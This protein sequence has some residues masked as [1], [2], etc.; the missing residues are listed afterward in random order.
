MATKEDFKYDVLA[1]LGTLEESPNEKGYDVRA[2]IISWNGGKP[3]LDIRKWNHDNS[4]MGKGCSMSID[5][6]LVLKE[7]L[8]STDLTKYESLSVSDDDI[9]F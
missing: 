1:D 7:V 4:L 9:D 3:K 8:N 5:A 6:A 2:K